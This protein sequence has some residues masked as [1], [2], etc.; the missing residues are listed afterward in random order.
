MGWIFAIVL[1]IMGCRNGEE[2]MLLASGLYAI[3]G[4][5]AFAKK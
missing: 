1:F 4:A 5:I 3:A 2:A